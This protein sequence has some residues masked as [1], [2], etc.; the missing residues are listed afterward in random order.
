MWIMYAL[1]SA[2]FA[3]VMSVL[4]KIGLKDVDS[5]LATALRTI[6]VAV[7]AWLI[8]FAAGTQSAIVEISGK[9]LLFLVLSGLATGGSWLCYFKALQSGD[10]NKIV[11]IDKSS[12][13]LTMLLSMLFLGEGITFLEICAMLLIAT[14]IYLMIERKKII[15]S[16]VRG[17][18][19]LL[20]AILSAVFA[21][22]TTILG[23]IGIE[24]VDSD[25]GTAIRTIVV[26]LMAWLIVFIQHK[27]KQLKSIDR[28]SWLF[29]LFSGLATGLSWLCYYR[30]LQQGSASVVV[31]IDKL[32]I[33]VTVSFG[34]FLFHERLNRNSVIGLVMILLGIQ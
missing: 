24:G 21:S 16:A 11:P 20:Y 7:F 34:Y 10:I 12:I 14:G 19:W 18:R 32:S 23:K 29:I 28:K 25:L 6:V 1:L 33:L 17:K 5:T 30:A 3:G 27:Q 31:S 13:V 15:T 9:T 2:L 4:A 26:L 22:L 8:V